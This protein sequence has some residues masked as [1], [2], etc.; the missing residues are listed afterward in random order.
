MHA[1]S[2]SS[3]IKKNSAS[4]QE[5]KD[6]IVV[7]GIYEH[8]KKKQYKVLSVSCCTDDLSW[9][10]VYEALYEN[11]VSQIWHRSLEEFLDNIT[12]EGKTI[13]R[14]KFIQ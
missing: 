2:E 1:T 3:Q 6:Q 7:G 9:W 11:P 5:L 14:F 12:I 10:V 4:L 13:P 8:Y